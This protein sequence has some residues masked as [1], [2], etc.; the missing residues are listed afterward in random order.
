MPCSTGVGSKGSGRC[1]VWVVSTARTNPGGIVYPP[2]SWRLGRAATGAP[3]VAVIDVVVVRN[4]NAGTRA[5]QLAVRPTPTLPL[6]VVIEQGA[7]ERTTL[8]AG[9]IAFVDLVARKEQ[10]VRVVVSDRRGQL[11]VREPKTVLVPFAPAG[12]VLVARESRQDEGA[13]GAGSAR[14]TPSQTCSSRQPLPT[15]TWV[16]MR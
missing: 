5:D 10:Q 8:R 7:F 3:D 4:A 15:M 6:V 2:S 12:V 13:F 1:E 9:Q 11:G 14:T 16:R